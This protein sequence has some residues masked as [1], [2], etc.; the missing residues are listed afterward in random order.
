[1][2]QF[3]GFAVATYRLDM[4][5]L[6]SAISCNVT[7]LLF[8]ICRCEKTILTL[9]KLQM[10]RSDAE[11]GVVMSHCGEAKAALLRS[12]DLFIMA[13]PWNH[14]GDATYFYSY[15]TKSNY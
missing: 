8:G 9:L 5:I 1:M 7:Q 10:E 11:C 2:I 12:H 3:M 13:R 15:C 14:C 6:V 4:P